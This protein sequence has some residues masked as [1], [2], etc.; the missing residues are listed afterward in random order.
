M[1]NRST[2]ARTAGQPRH[3]TLWHS[4]S[5]YGLPGTGKTAY[6]HALARMLDRP[7]MEQRA[8]DLLSPYVGETEQRISLAFESALDDDAVL[9]IDEADSLLANREHAVRNWEVSQVNELLEQLGDFEGVLVLA[10]NRLE[11]LDG[12][13]LRRLDAKIRFDPL[14]PEQA[15][16]SFVGLCGQLGLPCCTA[17]VARLASLTPGDFA[18]VV[19]RLAFAP[20]VQG[21]SHDYGQARVTALVALLSEEVRLKT[22]GRQP[23]GFNP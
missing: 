17:E 4:P 23:M 2:P 7:L 19:R 16:C 6:A 8:S 21:H 14:T 18:C 22:R 13:V 1:P 12:A 11:A 15:R 9:F 5:R 3:Q 20:P 10:T